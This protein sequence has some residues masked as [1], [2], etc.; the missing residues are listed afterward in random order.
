MERAHDALAGERTARGVLLAHRHQAGHL[1][2]GQADL[3]AAPVGE[4]EVG[5]PEVEAGGGR[6]VGR[7][8]HDALPFFL[9]WGGVPG[10]VPGA[11]REQQRRAPRLRF[12]RQGRAT[13]R[14]EAGRGEEA[15]EIFG[16]EA[17]ALLAH[18]AAELLAVVAQQ[19]HDDRAPPRLDDARH[20][21][22][23]ERRLVDL[24]Q[25]EEHERGIAGTVG[26]R[27][28]LEVA[29][30]EK[31]VV[32]PARSPPCRLQHLGRAV[33]ADDAPDPRGE[34]ER[35]GA[36]AAGEVGDHPV[37]RQ[38]SLEGET[39]EALAVE[40]GAQPLPLAGNAGEKVAPLAGASRQTTREAQPVVRQSR[41]LPGLAG[42]ELPEL[43][44]ALGQLAIRH[45]VEVR[46]TRAPA[47]QPT[48]TREQLQVPADA[49]LRHLQDVGE[50]RDRELL[51][52]Q[53]MEHAQA[54]RVGERGEPRQQEV[55]GVGRSA[56]HRG[57]IRKS[58]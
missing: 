52:L 57:C 18:L 29:L 56:L 31:D 15:G 25:G 34:G 6:F 41:P 53:E 23:R 35:G 37:G 10:H 42:G 22:D 13:D 38:Q 27:Q 46:C 50:L 51:L 3:V 26:D 58:G 49:R 2:L 45:A 39:G 11:A 44:R 1:L 36:A 40:L 48:L 19:V 47:H 7:D 8:G 16:G 17:G 20:L 28:A 24:G 30:F 33:D 4:G 54:R 55:G 21:G 43:A 12:R 32:H 5:H 14:V 9:R